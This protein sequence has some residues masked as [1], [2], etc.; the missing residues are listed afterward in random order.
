MIPRGVKVWYYHSLLTYNCGEEPIIQDAF[1]DFARRGGWAGLCFN[2]VADVGRLQPFTCPHFIEFRLREVS[3]KGLSGVLGYATPRLPCARFNIEALAEWS[4][5]VRGR[6]PREFATAW[7]VRRG[8]RAPELFADWCETLGP[9][10]WDVYGSAWPGGD[11]RKVPGHAA[12]LLRTG[13]LP[14]LGTVTWGL[15]RAPWGDIKSA[16][17]LEGD[18]RAAGRALQLARRLGER[19]F[20]EET[21]VVD[22]YVRSLWALWHLRE[23]A[24]D[25]RLAERN[26]SA[27]RRWFEEYH[28]ALSQAA[29]ALPRWLGAAAPDVAEE[30]WPFA[31]RSVGLLREMVREMA[32][33]A[34]QWVGQ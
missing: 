9:V 23:L 34:E 1:A 6:T 27:A 33:V 22:G 12:E 19:Q 11:R 14:P 10:A 32:A 25:G 2:V 8:L 29:D 15:F 28:A 4:W 3:G 21:L 13:K 5:N 26:K 17:Q 20:I 16:E 18:V 30:C 31:R 24:P 7:A